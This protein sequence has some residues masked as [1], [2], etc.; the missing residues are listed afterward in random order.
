[1]SAK[2]VA[3]VEV[4][5][6]HIYPDMEL[7]HF[8]DC[9]KQKTLVTGCGVC[10]DRYY[11]IGSFGYSANLAYDHEKKMFLC[12]KCGGPKALLNEYFNEIHHN[13]PRQD[14]RITDYRKI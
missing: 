14:I 3:D 10:R 1:M 4:I 9:K 12:V 13:R 5:E 7:A 2:Q 6:V 8:I 11:L